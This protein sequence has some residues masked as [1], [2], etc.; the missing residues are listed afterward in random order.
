ML[1]R[2]IALFLAAGAALFGAAWRLNDLRRRAE[3]RFPP[4]GRFVAVSVAGVRLHYVRRG[5]GVTVVLLHG[6]DGFWQDYAAILQAAGNEPFDC[7]AFDRPGHGYSDAPKSG[8]SS[9]SAQAAIL[10]EALHSLGL[11]RYLLV[12]HSWGGTLAL[13]FAL[14]Y[15][16]CAAGLVLVNPWAAPTHNPPPPL[17]YAARFAGRNLS[18]AALN[19][20]LLKRRLLANNLRAA[21]F[22]ALIPADYAEPAFALWQRSA[23]MAGAFLDENAIAWRELPALSKRYPEINVPVVIMAG[24]SDLVVS[25]IHHAQWLAGQIPGAEL[26]TLPNAG[27][28]I[29][30]TEPAA[31]IAALHACAA[32]IEPTE[33]MEPLEIPPFYAGNDALTRA[34]NLIL[35]YGWNATAYQALAPDMEYWFA[36]DG[37]AVVA[38][39]ARF[40]V[41]VAAGA[42]VCAAART[43]EIVRDFER[44]AARQG[45]GA[46]WFA[47]AGR[48]R[49]ALA[50]LPPHALLTIGAQPTWNP[51]HWTEMLRGAKSLRAQINRAKNKGVS[52]REIPPNEAAGRADLQN[53]LDDWMAHHPLPTL[54]FLTEPVTL[55]RLADRRIWI[56]EAGGVACAFLIATPIPARR[57][58][59]IEQIARSSNAPNGANELLVDAA[60]R[61]LAADGSDYVTLGLVPLARRADIS[62]SAASPS[63]RLLLRW[64][65]SHGRRFYN[66]AGLDA[67]KSKFQ[68]EEWEPL[69][70]LCPGKAVTLRALIATLA[71]FS[72]EPLPLLLARALS[73]SLRQEAAWFLKR[74]RERREKKRQP[75][76]RQNI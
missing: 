7:I 2:M 51:A 16:Q 39:V 43:A 62:H 32:R 65:R 17:L 69:Y 22:P 40:G 48:M 12:G 24:E 27:H 29:P 5:A 75:S 3:T 25:P 55:D 20:T 38:Y 4:A 71:A 15:P 33:G 50:D 76:N 63:A 28:E 73:G 56:A 47:A 42:P 14:D 18:F 68:P 45:C 11:T 44:D 54:H 26:L 6:S 35:R 19:L 36:P 59:M 34:R 66:F 9:L 74:L 70:L 58:W 64:G 72:R 13:Q 37:A 31:V 53:C 21:F 23:T 41:W 30:Q 10:H 1:W 46:C 49:D 8:D 67:F 52:V 60:M 57:G 61:N